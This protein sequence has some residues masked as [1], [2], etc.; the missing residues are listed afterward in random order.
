MNRIIVLE[1]L[2]KQLTTKRENL[3]NTQNI[4]TQIDLYNA[5]LKGIKYGM[6]IN[7]YNGNC[8]SCYY[9]YISKKEGE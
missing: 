5:E 8:A 7:K 2:I 4:D 3:I 1:K 6:A 9:Y